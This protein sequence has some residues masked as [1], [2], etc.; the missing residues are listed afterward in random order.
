MHGS[1]AAAQF[2]Q[3][4]GIKAARHTAG[5]LR[6]HLLQRPLAKRR[7]TLSHQTIRAGREEIALPAPTTIYTCPMD[8]EVRQ[9]TSGPVPQ[10]RH[11]ARTG[12]SPALATRTEYT[13][14]MHPEI[15]RAEPGSCPICGMALEPRT[16]HRRGRGKSGT[17][18]DDAPLLGQRR[19]R[20]SRAAPGNVRHDSRR[21]PCTAVSRC[22][23][24]AGSNSPS[25]RRWFSGAAGHFFERGWAS[26]VNRSLNMFTLIALGTGT[27][28]VYS[29][30]AVLFPEF[31]RRRSAVERRGSRLFRSGGRDHGAGPSRAGARAA[32]AQPHVVCDSRAAEAVS[33]NR[34]P[35]SRRRHRDRRSHRAHRAGDTL[36]VRPGEKVPVDGVVL[37]GASSVD[38]SL[39]TGES[40]PVEKTGQP[41]D[42]RNRERHRKFLMRAERVGGET[43][44]A[45][46]VRMVSEAQRS[47]APVQRLADRVASYFVPAVVLAAVDRLRSLGHCSAPSREWRTPC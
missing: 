14:P 32:R 47:R 35:G 26:L 19:A 29:V 43:M 36:R 4:G 5:S 11:G 10:V 31:S 40:I 12:R 38:E 27:A 24:S 16:A 6:S 45:Q 23:R 34:A 25:R 42:R 13:C 8:P 21:S 20:D 46:I 37:D 28:Y 2:V 3:L 7:I 22:A 33:A 39:V 9:D 41:R 30:I 17:R 1:G 18:L 15:I 44:L